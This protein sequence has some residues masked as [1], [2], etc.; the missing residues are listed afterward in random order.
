MRDVIGLAVAIALLGGHPVAAQ[1]PDPPK[2][3]PKGPDCSFRAATTCWTAWGPRARPLSS[4]PKRRQDRDTMPTLARKRMDQ[5]VIR[6][7]SLGLLAS[8]DHLTPSPY[9]P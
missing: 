1:A 5:A 9:R 3:P 8:P 6:K 2:P 4:I 7:D